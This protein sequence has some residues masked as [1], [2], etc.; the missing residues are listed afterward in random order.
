MH[1]IRKDTIHLML[2]LY[3][4]VICRIYYKTEDIFPKFPAP[5]KIQDFNLTSQ[6]LASLYV[7]R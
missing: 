2:D 3:V 1:L 6:A 5:K 7:V 4:S